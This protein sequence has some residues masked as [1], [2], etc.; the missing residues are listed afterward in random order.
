MELPNYLLRWWG[1]LIISTST[2]KNLCN[3]QYCN[4]TKHKQR[5]Q[6]KN[7]QIIS[8]C[9]TNKFLEKLSSPLLTWHIFLAFFG[10]L[11]VRHGGKFW[12]YFYFVS[13]LIWWM[14]CSQN[15]SLQKITKKHHWRGVYPNFLPTNWKR[16]HKSIDNI[17]KKGH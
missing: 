7:K 8:A 4:A 13:W 17:N 1:C 15:Y 14:G 2:N 5:I 11:F 9:V 16:S 10:D 12:C 6:K 3:P